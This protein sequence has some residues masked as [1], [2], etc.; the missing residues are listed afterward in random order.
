MTPATMTGSMVAFD[1]RTDLFEPA[2][3]LPAQYLASRF[4]MQPERRLLLAILEDALAT[5]RRA[6]T[7][8]RRRRRNPRSE[9][10]AWISSDDVRW[11]F[12]YLNICGTLGLDPY[13]LR[14]SLLQGQKELIPVRTA[15]L[16]SGSRTRPSPHR[17]PRVAQAV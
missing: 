5:G 12:S 4:S 15:R 1:G 7:S 8:K 10:R 6:D 16:H 14:R 11:P 13:Y 17:R 9:A 2:C 3:V